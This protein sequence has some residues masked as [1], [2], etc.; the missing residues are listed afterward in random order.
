MQLVRLAMDSYL[1]ALDEERYKAAYGMLTQRTRTILPFDKFSNLQHD[2]YRKSGRLI[3]RSMLKLTW[4]KYP[5][6]SPTSG[7]YAA[8]DFAGRFENIDRQCGYIVL[9]Q[10]AAS[11]PF[12]VMR[13]ENNFI[14]NDMAAE[15]ERQKSRGELDQMW[16]KLAANCPN[17]S[18][19]TSP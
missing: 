10:G 11:R 19:P 4:T 15:I 16:A 12:E 13:F 3:Q 14:D 2:F 9:Y 6:N 1:S 8:V 18:L 17:Y 5:E 7:V